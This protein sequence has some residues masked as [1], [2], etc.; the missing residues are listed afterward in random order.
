VRKT[1]PLVPGQEVELIN[2]IPIR[3]IVFFLLEYMASLGQPFRIQLF[4]A[5]VM[6]K[7]K[8]NFRRNMQCF[9]WVFCDKSCGNA[10]AKKISES[11]SFIKSN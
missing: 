11:K 2:N 7:R 1:Q 6:P 4:S 10:I 3:V 5:I 9:L 8:R